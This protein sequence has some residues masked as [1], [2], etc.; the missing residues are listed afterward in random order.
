MS[1]VT[2]P[3]AIELGIQ[4]HQ[5][6]RLAEAAAVYREIIAQHPNHSDALHLL[7]IATHQQG[8]H[9]A[10]IEF[11]DRAIALNPSVPAYHSNLGLIL[12]DLG[13]FHRASAAFEAALQL[14]GDHAEDYYN[15]GVVFQAQGDFE[16]AIDSYRQSIALA[17]TSAKARNNLGNVLR[18]IG[19]LDDSIVAYHEAITCVRPVLGMVQCNLGNALKG[20]GRLDQAIECYRQAVALQPGN[21]QMHSNLV[22]SLHFHPHYDVLALAKENRQW[23]ER[24]ADPLKRFI[25]IHANDPAPNRRLKIGYVSPNFCEQAECFF[26]VPLLENHNQDQFEIHCYSSVLHHDWISQRIQQ[27]GATWHD[28]PALSDGALAEKIRVDEVDIL[29][30]LTMHMAR[31]RLLL[32]ARKPAPV[33]V[34]WLAYPGST[35]L[36]TI[37]YRLTDALMEPRGA[38]D[39][40]SSEDPIR[41]P[42]A[43]CCY[44][45]LDAT[46][47]VG[48]LP[49][50]RNGYLTVGSLNN[51]C[52]HHA[53][54]WRLWAQALAAVPNSRLVLLAGE[55][56]HRELIRGMFA[57]AG[58]APERVNFVTPCSRIDY[59]KYYDQID[60]GLDPFPYNGIT[61]TCDALWMGVPVLSRVGNNPAARAGLS[62]LSTVGLSEFTAHT[63]EE[64][65]S[66]FVESARDLTRLAELRSNL[67]QRIQISPLMDGPRFT[68]HVELAYR[69]MWHKWCA[70]QTP[71]GKATGTQACN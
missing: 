43:W 46:P 37:D 41:L 32:F 9:Q 2:T 11:L 60:L 70:T 10:A 40:W 28:V 59:L 61:T 44:E 3:K 56:Q 24:H 52:K 54:V 18:A 27:T 25:P 55:G 36:D 19:R 22:Y 12:K 69:T 38:D 4:H 20:Q 64:F 51:L 6:G 33:Q 57:T 13:Q 68:R 21:E 62:L 42:D 48:A 8:N 7:G 5:A 31:S 30:D 53:D 34:T 26:V 49:A 71:A 29:I 1:A 67:R 58:I 45:P 66:K 15:L 50:L 16:R 35:G 63:D 23:R 65:I 47:P 17:P 39:S 14:R